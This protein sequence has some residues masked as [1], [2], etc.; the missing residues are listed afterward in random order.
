[1]LQLLLARTDTWLLGSSLSSM[2]VNLLIVVSAVK[3]RTMLLLLVLCC[4]C[5]CCCSCC[6]TDVYS[7]KS[8][9]TT[10][11]FYRIAR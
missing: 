2:F 1:M 3:V 4:S 5:S 11:A 7:W 6:Y 10:A 8:Y 9:A